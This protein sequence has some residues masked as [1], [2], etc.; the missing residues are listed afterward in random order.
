MKARVRA[1]K[2]V[3]AKESR[4]WLALRHLHQGESGRAAA[5]CGLS[6]GWAGGGGLRIEPWLGVRSGAPL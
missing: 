2:G 3:D 6:H 5:A 4:R 1:G